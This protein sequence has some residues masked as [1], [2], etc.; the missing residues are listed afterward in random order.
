MAAI[1]KQKPLA[2]TNRLKSEYKNDWSNHKKQKGCDT[3]MYKIIY[4]DCTCVYEKC[5]QKLLGRFPTEQE[6][7]EY[8]NDN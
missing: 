7:D 2:K 5:T 3:Q 1:P 4:P 8:I 6:A